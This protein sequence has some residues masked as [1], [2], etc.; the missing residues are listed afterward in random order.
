MKEKRDAGELIL[1][2]EDALGLLW[3]GELPQRVGDHN[4]GTHDR[5]CED[6]DVDGAWSGEH[7]VVEIHF[8]NSRCA[9]I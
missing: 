3:E 6:T 8:E 2:S 1:R 5:A 4:D 9:L 7:A